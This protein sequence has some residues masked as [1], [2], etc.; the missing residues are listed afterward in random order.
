[1]VQTNKA[2]PK[3]SDF[4]ISEDDGIDQNFNNCNGPSVVVDDDDGEDGYDI[5]GPTVQAHVELAKTAYEHCI[6]CYH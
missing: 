5:N 6:G 4:S 1:M 3:P 2:N